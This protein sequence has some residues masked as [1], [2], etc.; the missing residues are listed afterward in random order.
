MSSIK[1]KSVLEMLDHT[2][3][4]C[5]MGSTNIEPYHE[6]ILLLHLVFIAEITYKYKG[7]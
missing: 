2:V 1:K 6:K 7:K 4:I 5:R 3:Y